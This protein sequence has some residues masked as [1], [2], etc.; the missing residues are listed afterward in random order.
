MS[1]AM[2]SASASSSSSTTTQEAQYLAQYQ[3]EGKCTKQPSCCECANATDRKKTQRYCGEC[4]DTFPLC[5]PR[6]KSD[7]FK[8]HTDNAKA[9]RPKTHNTS[10]RSSLGSKDNST[11]PGPK[12]SANKRR[13]LGRA[14][15]VG[16]WAR[17]K[18]SYQ[19]IGRCGAMISYHLTTSAM[20]R[21]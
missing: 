9:G 10:R 21:A 15:P 8:R 17:R 6:T 5:H 4:G 19:R 12:D 2:L 7:C 18:Y 3:G 16:R 13:H 20:T 1:S 11:D 14:R